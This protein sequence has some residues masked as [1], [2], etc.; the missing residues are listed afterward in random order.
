M[1]SLRSVKSWPSQAKFGTGWS[2]WDKFGP[3]FLWRF[4]FGTPKF[5]LPGFCILEAQALSLDISLSYFGISLYVGIVT[6]SKFYLGG[7]YLSMEMYV[8][9]YIYKY[10]YINM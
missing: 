4:L 7:L 10:V 1:A 6:F 5:G 9:T 2:F 8:Y 3:C